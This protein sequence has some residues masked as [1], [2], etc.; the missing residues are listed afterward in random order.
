MRPGQHRPP[1]LFQ[2]RAWQMEQ[3][4]RRRIRTVVPVNYSHARRSVDDEPAVP[5][6]IYDRVLSTVDGCRRDSGPD[7]RQ[8]QKGDARL[9]KNVGRLSQF[10]RVW[11][12]GTKVLRS[13]C[14]VSRPNALW[15]QE[16]LVSSSLAKITVHFRLRSRLSNSLLCLCYCLCELVDEEEFERRRTLVCRKK[17]K[18]IKWKC[19]SDR[20]RDSVPCIPPVALISPSVAFCQKFR[21][22]ADT[23][24]RY[25]VRWPLRYAVLPDNYRYSGIS[26]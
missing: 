25:A 19:I 26:I 1:S 20:M 15:Q 5:A 6:K 11:F 22:S 2:L 17:L 3:K 18:I 13:S 21:R 16:Q 14:A 10:R 9:V 7:T 24:S 4:N 23:T 12:T 8:Q